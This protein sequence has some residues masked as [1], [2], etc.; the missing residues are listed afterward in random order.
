[1]ISQYFKTVILERGLYFMKRHEYNID[2]VKKIRPC[3]QIKVLNIGFM[4]FYF[5]YILY[6]ECC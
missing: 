5:Y 1:M 4:I 6:S 2:F 3:T